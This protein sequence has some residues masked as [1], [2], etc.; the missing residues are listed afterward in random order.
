M[1]RKI[2]YRTRG[3]AKDNA[4]NPPSPNESQFDFLVNNGMGLPSD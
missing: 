4:N 1:S 3:V 2:R